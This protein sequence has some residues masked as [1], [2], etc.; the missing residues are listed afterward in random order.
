MRQDTPKVVSTRAAPGPRG[1]A[2]RAVAEAK[3]AAARQPAA[4]SEREGERTGGICGLSGTE[5]CCMSKKR[6]EGEER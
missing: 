4:K 2:L 1:C 5:R 6:R 3:E